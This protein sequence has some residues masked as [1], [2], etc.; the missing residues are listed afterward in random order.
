MVGAVAGGVIGLVGGPGG[1]IAGAAAGVLITKTVRRVGIEVYDRLM[2][3]RQQERVAAVLAVVLVDAERLSD[4]GRPIREDGFFDAEGERRSGAEEL[5][6]GVLLQAANSYQER[7]LRHL[8]AIFPNLATRPDVSPAD[9]H[10]LSRLADRLTWRQLE[11]LAVFANPQEERLIMRDVEH[12]Q[13]GH[14]LPTPGLR[15]EVEELGN[16]GL[17]GITNTHEE[18]VRAGHTMDTMSGLWSAPMARWRLT[19]QGRLLVEIARLD[20]VPE[21][22]QDAVLKELLGES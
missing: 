2:V 1:A 10:W 5:L 4:S 7:K 8:G 9:G 15:E 13:T 19:E 16:L 11:L 3:R 12:D 6:E 20:D 21:N 17:L 14:R 22:D 18:T